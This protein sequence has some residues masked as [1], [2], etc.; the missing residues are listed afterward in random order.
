MNEWMVWIR[1]YSWVKGVKILYLCEGFKCVKDF[2][3][4]EWMKDGWV[5]EGVD[6]WV[7]KEMEAGLGRGESSTVC[8][9]SAW[10]CEY[11]IFAE[12]HVTLPVPREQLCI[13]IQEVNLPTRGHVGGEVLAC[14]CLLQS[15]LYC[16]G[17]VGQLG[18]F[19]KNECFYCACTAEV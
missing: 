8:L 16:G 4:C 2:R 7:H 17:A 19:R 11:I 5:E 14:L 18:L 1:E 6:E 12:G 9:C 3:M 15:S 13:D 10:L